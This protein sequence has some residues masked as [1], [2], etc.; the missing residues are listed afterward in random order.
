MKITDQ[1]YQPAGLEVTRMVR[2]VLLDKLI[3]MGR[4]GGGPG[5]KPLLILWLNHKLGRWVMPL[6]MRHEL[7]IH[8]FLNR[9]R[10]RG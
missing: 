4:W 1:D 3:P 5:K 2:L 6:A 9:I 10:R 7:R 8:Q